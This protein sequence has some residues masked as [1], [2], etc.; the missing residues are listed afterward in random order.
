MTFITTHIGGLRGNFSI[1]DCCVPTLRKCACLSVFLAKYIFPVN[2][3]HI[4]TKIKKNP[5]LIIDKEYL[6]SIICNLLTY[7]LHI[8]DEQIIHNFGFYNLSLV[9]N[10]QELN[11]LFSILDIADTPAKHIKLMFGPIIIG[12]LPYFVQTNPCKLFV[13]SISKIN[14]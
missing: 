2:E 7:L 13:C 11:E 8:K 3:E 4:V 14:L 5:H 6:N 1:H 10:K 12:N 9:K